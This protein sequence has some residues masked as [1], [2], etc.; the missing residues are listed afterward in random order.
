MQNVTDSNSLPN[1]LIYAYPRSILSTRCFAEVME[2]EMFQKRE[3]RE[4]PGSCISKCYLRLDFVIWSRESAVL[5]HHL[6]SLLAARHLHRR[7][8]KME[9]TPSNGLESNFEGQMI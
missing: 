3:N 6:S 5:Q 8:N 7:S 4:S 1:S 2:P 9:K